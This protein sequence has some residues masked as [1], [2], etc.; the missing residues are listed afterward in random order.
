M[1]TFWIISKYHLASLPKIAPSTSNY[2]N[3][4]DYSSVRATTGKCES[5]N[6]NN[7]TSLSVIPTLN[8]PG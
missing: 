4:L 5:N 8:Y 1:R 2:F 3:F 6:W 7:P